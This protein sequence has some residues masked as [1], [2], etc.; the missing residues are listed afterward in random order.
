MKKRGTVKVKIK[1][2]APKDVLY[3]VIVVGGGPAGLTAASNT[4]LRGLK[5]LL[6]EA[7]KK[8]GGKPHQ[9][10]SE[11]CVFDHPG[12]PEGVT[13]EELAH[14]LW[15]QAHKNNVIIHKHEQMTDLDVK[16]T[17]KTIKTSKGSYKAKAVIICTGLL[18]IPRRLPPLENYKGKGVHYIVRVPKRYKN[19]NIL[20]VGSGDNAFDNANMLAKFAKSI[21]L[22]SRGDKLSAKPASIKLAKKNKVNILYNTELEKL[23]DGGRI[24][25][26]HLT[27][28]KTKK[29]TI[30]KT[31]AVI[32]NIG[33][34]SA[35]KFL[36]E[37]GMKLQK[38]GAIKVDQH[39]QSSI[40]GVFAAGDVAGQLN[41]ISIACS[42]GIRAALGVFKYLKKDF[43]LRVHR[44]TKV[45]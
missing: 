15:Q 21:T 32:I 27:N 43:V 34:L 9:F 38:T 39:M 11:K 26:A 45:C 14:R 13:G 36:K 5:T 20:I 23:T 22:I 37:L 42:S 1:G 24:H 41:L 25:K 6:I 2:K 17:V 29:Q 33:F 8:T 10:Y 28:N 40:K 35:Q 3:D 44:E 12:F 18:S 7:D 16:N 19:K 31:N 4:A 30:L